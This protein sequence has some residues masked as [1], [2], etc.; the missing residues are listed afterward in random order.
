MKPLKATLEFATTCITIVTT[1]LHVSMI[2]STGPQYVQC[3]MLSFVHTPMLPDTPEPCCLALTTLYNCIVCKHVAFNERD[4]AMYVLEVISPS[5][6]PPSHPLHSAVWDSP[7][8][9]SNP[10][11]GLLRPRLRTLCADEVKGGYFVGYFMHVESVGLSFRR[12]FSW[13]L[14]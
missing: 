10:A 11:G 8:H 14:A 1:L 13:A 6:H 5:N 9:R 12:L 4:I 7:H 3:L 2:L